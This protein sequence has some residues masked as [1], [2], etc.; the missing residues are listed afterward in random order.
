M[1]IA[2]ACKLTPLHEPRPGLCI[3]TMHPRLTSQTV[4]HFGAD[5]ASTHLDIAVHGDKAGVQRI[6]NSAPAIAQWLAQVPPGSSLAMESTG[7]YH[8]LLARLAHAQG[9]QVYV[10]NPRDVSHYARGVGQRGKTDRL[11]AQVI[12]R[13]LAHE[14]AQLRSWQP[15][16]PALAE[17]DSLLRRRAALV[18]HQGALRQSMGEDPVARALLPQVMAPL[19]QVLQTLDKRIAQVAQGIEGAQQALGSITSVPGLGALSGAALLVLFTRLAQASADAVVAFTELD[20]RPMDSGH[21]RG[22]RRL[23]KRGPPELRRLMFN[24]AMSASRTAAWRE[25]YAREI[26]KGLPRTAALVVLARKLVRVAFSLFKNR[27]TFDPAHRQVIKI[28]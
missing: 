26:A 27:T 17:L 14:H 22:V 20:P 6:A 18:R 8:L 21:K 13:Y 16:L 12:A 7:R 24:A 2:D 15:V 4:W 25:V 3:V 5:V 10:L 9:L 1:A 28:A 11:D 23:S 19:A